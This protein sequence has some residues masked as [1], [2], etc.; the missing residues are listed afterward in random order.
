LLPKNT[1]FTIDVLNR[2]IS[3][4]HFGLLS[5]ENDGLVKFLYDI[6]IDIFDESREGET[7][8]TN[9]FSNSE[10]L[11]PN[12]STTL[13]D[14]SLVDNNNQP[15]AG[16]SV[17]FRDSLSMKV[18]LG[19]TND[20]GRFMILLPSEKVYGVRLVDQ[21]IRVPFNAISTVG[22]QE[23]VSINLNLVY[24]YSEI[25]K[26]FKHVVDKD[27]SRNKEGVINENL[28]VLSN[29]LFDFDKA[30]IKPAAYVVLNQILLKI[31]HRSYSII[32]VSGHTDSFGNENYNL[33]LS[34][35][36][37][38]AVM[39]YLIEMGINPQK[40][41]SIG[42]GE[43]CPVVSNDTDKGREQNRRTEIR[44]LN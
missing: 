22:G 36:R 29:V 35:D 40:I 21:G 2:T 31:K 25:N 26:V 1:E 38:N 42:K 11:Q 4:G 33:E 6:R 7:M 23:L 28:F 3:V 41:R 16:R 32:E 44:L 37:A 9:C 19:Q 8:I 27:V 30:V 13:I 17:L 14:V 12:D 20:S 18:Y 34:E 24:I 10:D 5:P 39:T 15:I 43:L